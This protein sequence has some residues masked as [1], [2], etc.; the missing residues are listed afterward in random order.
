MKTCHG[1]NY[2]IACPHC[3]KINHYVDD[4]VKVEFGKIAIFKKVCNY[5]QKIVY[6]R[7]EY[8]LEITASNADILEAVAKV[9]LK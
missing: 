1:D 5:C 2:N 3:G 9:V 6:Y 4:G 8:K 7:A